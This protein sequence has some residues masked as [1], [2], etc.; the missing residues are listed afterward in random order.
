MFLTGRGGLA[1]IDGR[2]RQV[3]SSLTK[4]RERGV[5]APR[6]AGAREAKDEFST[7]AGVVVRVPVIVHSAGAAGSPVIPPRSRVAT[8]LH[9]AK[10]RLVFV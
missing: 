8:R 6:P 7:L 5:V 9:S 4:S 3:G 2:A 10:A 1:S